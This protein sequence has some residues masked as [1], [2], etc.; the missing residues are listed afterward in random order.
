MPGLNVG[1]RIV[2]GA[3]FSFP[4]VLFWLFKLFPFWEKFFFI[5]GCI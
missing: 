3:L 4:A 1:F 5:F 2:Q